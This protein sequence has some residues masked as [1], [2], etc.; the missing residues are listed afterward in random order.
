MTKNLQNPAKKGGKLKFH[1]KG[2]KTARIK[3]IRAVSKE[4]V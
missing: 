3:K 1:K 2:G 4:I